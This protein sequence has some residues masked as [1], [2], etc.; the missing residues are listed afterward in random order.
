M[1]AQLEKKPVP[2]K[3]IYRD[4]EYKVKEFQFPE[5]VTMVYVMTSK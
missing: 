1:V 4:V 3:F 2:I 5:H